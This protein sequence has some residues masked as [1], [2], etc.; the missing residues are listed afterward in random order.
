[1]S[2]TKANIKAG[3]TVLSP[4][5]YIGAIIVV[6][7]L[8]GMDWVSIFLIVIAG[9]MAAVL[10]LFLYDTG[11]IHSMLD[12]WDN[13]R[14]EYGADIPK[15]IRYKRHLSPLFYK[16]DGTLIPH[17]EVWGKFN[18]STF[19]YDGVYEGPRWRGAKP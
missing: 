15:P 16:A 14:I 4:L 13:L 3:L 9:L 8:F 12:S 10:G 5:I 6:C 7:L 19:E 1:M 18:R 17:D 2:N 11:A